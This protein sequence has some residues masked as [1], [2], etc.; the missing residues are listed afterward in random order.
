MRN[1]L[2]QLREQALDCS[3]YELEIQIFAFSKDPGHSGNPVTPALLG[4]AA[5]KPVEN[6]FDPL[7]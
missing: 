4:L 3:N 7:L 2:H 5:V 1:C 6:R